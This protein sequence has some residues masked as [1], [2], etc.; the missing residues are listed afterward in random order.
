[1]AELQDRLRFRPFGTRPAADLAG[2]LLPHAIENDRLVHLAELVVG[3]CRQ[4]RIVVPSP[5]ALERIC[6][7]ARYQARGEVQRR[8]TDGLSAEAI[9]WLSRCRAKM[10]LS[11]AAGTPKPPRSAASHSLLKPCPSLARWSGSRGARRRRRK[12][13]PS[14]GI[15]QELRR[16]AM[17]GMLRKSTAFLPRYQKFESISLQRRVTSEPCGMSRS[18]PG[19]DGGFLRMRNLFNAIKGLAHAGDA[20]YAGSSGQA[21]ASRSTHNRSAAIVV[22][23]SMAR[24]VVLSC[25]A[26]PRLAAAPRRFRAVS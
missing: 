6:V 3:E 19:P 15:V 2:W 10:Y 7:Q 26:I 4:R 25:A 16:Y 13:E 18:A 11:Y 5:G 12:A 1:V 17:P 9:C 21:G 23:G 22:S 14:G 20:A 24:R 8:L